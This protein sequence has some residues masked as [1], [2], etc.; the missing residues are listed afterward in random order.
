MRGVVRGEIGADVAGDGRGELAGQ[1]G[2]G[3][4][5][6]VQETM[7][8]DIVSGACVGSRRRLCGW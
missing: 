1:R 5:H 4:A 7:V 6:S 3:R 2:S 8:Q